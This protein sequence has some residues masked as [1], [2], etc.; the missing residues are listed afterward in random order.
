MA[1]LDEAAIYFEIAAAPAPQTT[2]SC[3]PAPPLQPIAPMILPST[4][5][6]KP[7]GEAVSIGSSV[8]TYGWPDSS[9][10]KNTMLSRRKR[11]AVHALCCA[12]TTEASCVWSI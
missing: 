8:D 1:E 10:S 3:E 7:P 11:A 4:M 5:I 2:A 12:I 9:A 6:G